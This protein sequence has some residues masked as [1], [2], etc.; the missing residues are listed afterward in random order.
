MKTKNLYLAVMFIGIISWSCNR[1]NDLATSAN[2]ESLKTSIDKGVQNLTSAVNTITASPGYQVF[3]GANN[4]T[5]KS[6]IIS[7]LDTITH[8]ILLSDIAGIYQYKAKT[9]KK[10]RFSVMHFFSKTGESSQM[11]VSLP[12]EKVKNPM[13][14][15]WY[16]P[17]D[18]LLKNDYVISVSDYLVKFNLFR[19]YD[20]QM[21]SS[22]KI[23]DVNAGALKIQT[24]Y[25]K[26]LSYHYASQFD[27]PNGY[28]TKCFYASGD[29]AVSSYSINQGAKTLYEEKYTAIKNKV[30][31][32]P[33]EM[34]YSL[35]IG[36]VL[37]ERKLGFGKASLDSA[38]VYVGGVLQLKSKVEIVD[39]A[40]DTTD[41]SVTCKKRELKITFDDGTS[42]TFSQLAGAVIDD[43]NSLF[44]SM[45]QVNFAT[46]IVD[47]I[48]WDIYTKKN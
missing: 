39:T 48:A 19:N 3:T 46:Q 12:E 28:T 2:S 14:L 5:T 1:T 29:T 40:T 17:A 15:L 25:G 18:T 37:I 42:S 33:R 21:A 47:W 32:K 36:N 38:K 11:I 41:P 26:N 35:K 43:I 24:A 13:K 9:V 23:K 34:E 8:N 27:F 6:A 4:L 45:R 7:P 31:F 16:A 44:T 22:I 20:Y 30:N 10:G